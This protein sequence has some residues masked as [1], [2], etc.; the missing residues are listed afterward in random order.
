MWNLTF[1]S[2]GN[3]G[4]EGCHAYKPDHKK[5][6]NEVY[7]GYYDL[8]TDRKKPWDGSSDLFRPDGFDCT[9]NNP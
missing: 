8:D 7:Y 1:I 6:A 5:Y 4:T 2:R 9:S 3:Y